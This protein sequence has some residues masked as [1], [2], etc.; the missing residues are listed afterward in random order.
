MFLSEVFQL[1]FYLSEGR[2][3]G[4]EPGILTAHTYIY[5]RPLKKGGQKGS[6]PVGAALRRDPK[7]WVGGQGDGLAHTPVLSHLDLNLNTRGKLELHQRVDGLGR[8]RVD[9]EDTLKGAE[10]ELLAGLLVYEGRAVH[11]KNLLVGGQGYRTADDG[12]RAFY[13]LNDLLGRLIDEVVIE[14]L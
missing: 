2:N 14:R 3:T 10:L 11:R 4:Q 9:V 5:Y 6:L 1:L 12:T 13:G 8:R 7:G